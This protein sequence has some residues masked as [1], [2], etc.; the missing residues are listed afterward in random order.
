VGIVHR[1]LK[2]DNVFLVPNLVGGHAVKLLDFGIA[3][4]LA[5]EEALIR[6]QTGVMMGTPEYMAPEQI[7]A[8]PIDHRTDVYALGAILF[9]ML[10]GRPP[11]T[12][13]QLGQL[14][15]K[16][17]GEP[18]VAPSTRRPETLHGPIPEALDRVVLRC[19]AKK[20]DDR[21]QTMGQLRE[22]LEGVRDP[23]ALPL[24][25]GEAVRATLLAALV[26]VPPRRRWPVMVAAGLGAAFLVG[27][28]A[29]VM[30]AS[31]RRDQA[32]VTVAATMALIS[33]PSRSTRATAPAMRVVGLASSPTGAK[34]FDLATGQSLGQTP[35][36]ID[37][38]VGGR[39]GVEL[40]LSGHAPGRVA[41]VA[42]GAPREVVNLEPL[43]RL[44]APV[45]AQRTEAVRR[46]PDGSRRSGES[47]P[48]PRR[49]RPV[50]TAPTQGGLS[51]TVNPFD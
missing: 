11:F 17:L 3:K 40:R 18:P 19:L 51:A 43:P 42:D 15:L 12:A 38:T 2:P 23:G 1:D 46:P 28:W 35:L 29:W 5:P 36:S 7:Q 25:A 20:P 47:H 8:G 24:A 31:R 44:A 6:T 26:A 33:G 49:S 21:V 30:P 39:R 4:F 10:T 27:A 9:E 50:R 16:Q 34:V 22:I 14:L 32:P 45:P 37:V 41:L 48:A 13:N